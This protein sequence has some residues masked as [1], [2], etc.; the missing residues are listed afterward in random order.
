MTTIVVRC[1]VSAFR[2]KSDVFAV[3]PVVFQVVLPFIHRRAT[4][5]SHQGAT[6]HPCQ[7]GAYGLSPIFRT[8][9]IGA[10]MTSEVC[11]GKKDAWNGIQA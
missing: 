1:A 5:I 4:A 8:L 6:P 7:S 3:G 10:M 11:D 9:S 2:R